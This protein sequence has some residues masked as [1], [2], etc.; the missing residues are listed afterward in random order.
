[1]SR[2]GAW[3]VMTS[4]VVTGGGCWRA[5]PAG[6]PAGTS[7]YTKAVFDKYQFE[8]EHPNGANVVSSASVS[9]DGAG[10]VEE[11]FE[12]R[13]GNVHLTLLNGRLTLNG[14]DR[15][16]VSPGDRIRLTADGRLLVNDQERPGP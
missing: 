11:K 2:L 5:G 16:T 14:A 15:G 3:V 12:H 8:A 7:V 1:M 10:N 9:K 6:A 13:V 4:A